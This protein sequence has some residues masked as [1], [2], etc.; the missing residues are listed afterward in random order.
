MMSD[1]RNQLFTNG[2]IKKSEVLELILCRLN[3]TK[4]GTLEYQHLYSIMLAVKDMPIQNLTN[5]T[6]APNSLN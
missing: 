5:Q 1:G 3:S 4:V 6:T 2:L